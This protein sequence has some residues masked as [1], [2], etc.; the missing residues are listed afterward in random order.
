MMILRVDL[1]VLGQLPDAITQQRDL[2]F[3]RPAVGLVAAISPED[4]LCMRRRA[5][6]TFSHILLVS[7]D[8]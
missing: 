3:G 1:E 6:R 4:L 2:H 8:D 5:V 7:A